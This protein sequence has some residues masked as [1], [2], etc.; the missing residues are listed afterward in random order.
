M[1]HAT[2]V[3]SSNT[4]FDVQVCCN[5]TMV[6]LFKRLDPMM[7]KGKEHPIA[8]FVC[9]AQQGSDMWETHKQ[10]R[11]IG[12]INLQNSVRTRFCL[13]DSPGTLPRS[14]L[15][16]ADRCVSLDVDKIVLPSKSSETRMRERNTAFLKFVHSSKTLFPNLPMILKACRTPQSH[17][18]IP[19][20]EPHK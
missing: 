4:A 9:L 18:M 17:S 16:I 19:R 2:A 13:F 5:E 11:M 1:D 20:G 12:R 3:F 14:F 8:P 15:E 7:L 10:L 6:A